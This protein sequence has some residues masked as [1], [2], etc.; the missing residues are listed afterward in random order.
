MANTVTQLDG[1][2]NC[3]A[4]RKASRYLTASYD[5]ALAPI[6]LRATQFTILQKIIGGGELSI[7]ELAEIIGMDRTTIATNL[8]PLIRAGLVRVDVSEQ[9]LRALSSGESS[10][11]EIERTRTIQ[12]TRR[13]RARHAPSDVA[14][15][16][17]E[18]R[19]AGRVH[20]DS[21]RFAIV[22][23]RCFVADK[24]PRPRA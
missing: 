3:L 5:Q 8:K 10:R 22:C 6:G 4:L 11:M 1:T 7:K 15:R 19:T 17:V 14:R 9:A 24:Q 12:Y 2:C 20:G 23:R 13:G 21:R 18:Q 16:H